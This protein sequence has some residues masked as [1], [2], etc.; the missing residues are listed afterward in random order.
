MREWDVAAVISRPAWFRVTAATAAEARLAV[1]NG[2]GRE[3][4]P[5]D[6]PGVDDVITVT[7]VQR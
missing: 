3:T 4:G 7:E 5:L 2:G 1:L 6:E